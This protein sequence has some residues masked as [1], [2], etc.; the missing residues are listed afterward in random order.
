MFKFKYF[1][2][3][4][5]AFLVVPINSHAELIPHLNIISE[6]PK[7]P[8]Y[9]YRPNDNK[10]HPAIV[11][12]HG[13]EGGNGDYWYLPGEKPQSIGA[14][15]LIPYIARYYAT[16]GYVTYAICYFDCQHLPG[17]SSYP[18]D[19]LVNIDLMEVTYKAMKWLKESSYVEN[20]KLV[21]W[22]ASRGAEQ[23]ILLSSVLAKLKKSN[24]QILLPDGV[25]SISPREKVALAFPKTA[26]DAIISGQRISFGTDQTSWLFDG[27]PVSANSLIDIESFP[28]PVLISSFVTDFVWGP[29]DMSALEKQYDASDVLKISNFRTNSCGAT[30]QLG[31]NL[32]RATFV[33]FPGA[34][35]CFP[36]LGTA[37]SNSFQELLNYFM[38]KVTNLK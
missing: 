15:G 17:Y 24:P 1:L 7:F 5:Y 11:L 19:E 13:S 18:P 8:G 38:S 14:D 20:K 34:G 22:G 12:L 28:N 6:K 32:Q 27:I 3:F 33:E 9:L 37:E 10:S 36:P 35:H 21:L 26:A 23:A 16:L 31:Q 4:V 30:L 25:I 2:L 29:T